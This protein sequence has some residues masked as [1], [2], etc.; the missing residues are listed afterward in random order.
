[1]MN[2]R[3]FPMALYQ[4]QVHTD[5]GK[6]LCTFRA[7]V[8]SPRS[9]AKLSSSHPTTHTLTHLDS[10]PLLSAFSPST[11]ATTTRSD[12]AC[13]RDTQAILPP[14]TNPLCQL[15]WTPADRRKGPDPHRMC[16][17]VETPCL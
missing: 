2:Q 7:E 13:G 12:R 11:Y 14:V 16:L 10:L 5:L 8:C 4:S 15:D 3:G 6:Y 17:S 1:M 9:R